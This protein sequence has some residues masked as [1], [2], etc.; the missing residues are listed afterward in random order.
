MLTLHLIAGEGLNNK[1]VT[2]LLSQMDLIPNIDASSADN[3]TGRALGTLLKELNRFYFAENFFCQQGVPITI[4]IH[5]HSQ[6]IT[7]R[8]VMKTFPGASTTLGADPSL[9]KSVILLQFIDVSP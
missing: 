8:N 5:H 9:K 1:R 6:K 4:V 3:G 7:I 2:Y